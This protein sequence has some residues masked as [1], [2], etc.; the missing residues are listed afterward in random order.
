MD[1]LSIILI[2]AAAVIGALA[3]FFVVRGKNNDS[4]ELEQQNELIEAQKAQ[5]AEAQQKTSLL[6]QQKE[7]AEKLL[8]DARQE[9]ASFDEKM[10][11]MMSGGEVD[12]NL[13]QRF[14]DAD[15]LKK[16]I[17]ELEGE[18][19][20]A[21]DDLA[22][23]EKK[24]KNK[25]SECN[26]LQSK[27]EKLESAY[28]KSVRE[29]G[30]IRS[31][32]NQKKEELELKMGSLEF[33]QSILTAQITETEDIA[34]LNRN[35]DIFESFV[36]GQ[37]TDLLSYL[38]KAGYIAW[39]NKE[40]QEGLDE[41]RTVFHSAFDQWSATKRKSWLDGKI[42]IAFIGEFSA[43]KTSI[44]NRILSQDNPNVPL[45]PV[46][47]KATTAIP[48][49]IA[50]G[51]KSSY[52]FISD[53]KRKT[54]SE[55]TFKSV[56]KE[57]LDQ[58]KGVSS[59]IKYFVMTYQNAN[60]NGLSILDTPGFNSSDAEDANRTIE[61]I[62]ECDALFWVFDVNA[63]TI[64]K[65]S[66]NL[67]KN[68][69]EKPLF[70]IINKVDTKSK[71]DV[72]KVEQ[73][74]RN[75][76]QR[77]GI[78]VKAYIRFSKSV[79]LAD[80]MTPIKSVTRDDSRDSFVQALKSNIEAL[81]GIL[82]NLYK[83]QNQSVSTEEQNCNQL[84]DQVINCLNAMANECVEA[85]NIP[86]WETHIFSSDRYEMSA[87]EGNRLMELLQSIAETR[88]NELSGLFDQRINAAHDSQQAYSFLCDIKAALQ[89][90]NECFNEFK[91][92][93]KYFN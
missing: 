18:L 41:Q 60:L 23:T 26:E 15:K 73:L 30:D 35:I 63:G 85:S 83:E 89:K 68:K 7:K 10:K 44:V 4:G 82:E 22:D 53:N 17:K 81:I 11:A 77:E 51:S 27:N 71:S 19:E 93:S 86:H 49:Y 25:S 55:S 6:A 45:L 64:N 16:R 29:I 12:P 33:V 84:T 75:T 59:L 52:T 5:I 87:W 67:I 50:G 42:S 13:A 79:P 36:K 39:N 14:A 76:L 62:N 80:I 21:E 78:D 34:T 9:I 66:I 3:T 92:V 38:F 57:I 1:A 47:T 54:I 20:D 90:A 32:L 69:L 61:V 91:K 72:D 56:S 31:E 70:V 88:I 74:I 48:T 2:I 43:G 46:S 58:V 65:T 37:Y 40:G 24:L 28:E 8:S